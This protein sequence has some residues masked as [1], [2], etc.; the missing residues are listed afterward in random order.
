M[1]IQEQ[2]AKAFGSQEINTLTDKKSRRI[3]Q[4]SSVIN[5]PNKTTWLG[6]NSTTFGGNN[7]QQV[8]LGVS[9]FGNQSFGK[10]S[11]SFFPKP[12]VPFEMLDLQARANLV[13]EFLI[14]RGVCN[15]NKEVA[16]ALGLINCVLKDQVLPPVKQAKK[17]LII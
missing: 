12:I 14:E 3:Q 7:S 16:K 2:F 10:S 13:K 15:I 6:V 5:T 17:K 9:Q 8:P 1:T 4:G 11:G